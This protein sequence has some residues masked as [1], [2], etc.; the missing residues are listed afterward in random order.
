[1]TDKSSLKTSWDEKLFGQLTLS[2]VVLLPIVIGVLIFVFFEYGSVSK[3]E[4]GQIGEFFGGW[5]TPIMLSF[6]LVLLIFSVRFQ[7]NQL[8]LTREEL[9]SSAESQE[10]AAKSQAD[11]LYHAQRSFELEANAK[12]LINLVEQTEGFV[13]TKVNLYV[14]IINFDNKL[15]HETRLFNL[16]DNWRKELEQGNEL[17]I[18]CRNERDEKYV[19]KYLHSLHHEL[20]VCQSLIRNK[21]WVYL[22]PYLNSVRE[23]LEA[24]IT[25]HQVGLINDKS[26]WMIKQAVS[27]LYNKIQ[28]DDKTEALVGDELIEKLLKDTFRELLFQLPTPEAYQYEDDKE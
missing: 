11:M 3:N 7:V 25:L 21:G 28:L 19:E 8:Q 12:G 23:Q 24:T 10:Q 20:Y 9:H 27:A 22:S 6:V 17:Q 14:D 26:I 4:I 16:I 5:L 13:N 2:F 18:K 15:P 1:M